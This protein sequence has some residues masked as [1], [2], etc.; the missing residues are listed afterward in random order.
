MDDIDLLE[1]GGA[2]DDRPFVVRHLGYEWP[3]EDPREKHYQWVLTALAVGSTPAIPQDLPVWQHRLA[4]EHWCAAW[5]LPDFQS[6][7][8]L[9]YLVDSYRPAIVHDLMV[10]AGQDLGDLWRGRRWRLLL[11][12][13]DRLPAHSWYA[14]AVSQDEEHAKMLAEAIASQPEGKNDG[15]KQHP[16]LTTWTPEVAA[17]TNVLD[18]VRSVQH[19]IV[20]VNSEKG[21]APKPPD[22]APRPVTPLEKAIKRAQFDRRKAKHDALAAR[23]LPHKSTS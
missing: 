7:R 23:M 4:F 21:K 19:A 22:P 2:G 5:D 1:H 17:M 9:A 18:A 10:H 12:I 14:A 15:D 11:D 3:L 8:R 16:S 6:A 13:I 20:A